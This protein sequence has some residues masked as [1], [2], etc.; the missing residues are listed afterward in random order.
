M[1]AAFLLLAVFI[2]CVVEAVEALTIVLAVGLTRGWRS[3]LAGV[4]AGVVVLAVVVAVLGPALRLIPLDVLRLVVGGLLLVFGLGWVRKAV[5]R[6]ANVKA[7]HD[8]TAIYAREV[9]HAEV[10]FSAGRSRWDGYSATIAFKAVVL[11][12]LEVVFI[13][14]TFGSNQGSIGLAVLGAAAAVVLV[15]AFGVAL[16]AP[17][18]RVPENTLKYVVGLLLVSFGTFWGA[19]GAGAHWPGADL[20]IPVLLGGYALLALAMTT[21]LRRRSGVPVEQSP[22]TAQELTSS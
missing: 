5:L 17:L 16:R 8:E 22:S 20:A 2:A 6:S 15:T 12:G 10:G 11:E 1:S 4:G 14:L 3:T 19:E 13:V 18:A 9:D 7:V 21:W